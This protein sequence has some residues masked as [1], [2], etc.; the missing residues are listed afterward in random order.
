M[1]KTAFWLLKTN[2]SFN[3][4]KTTLCHITRIAIHDFCTENV[5]HN[6]ASISSKVRAV[7]PDDSLSATCF[8]TEFNGSWDAKIGRIINGCY[9]FEKMNKCC[10]IKGLWVLAVLEA[11]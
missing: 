9:E 8:F 11:M 1:P 3:V 5:G 6:L 4:G 7:I 2:G 10:F